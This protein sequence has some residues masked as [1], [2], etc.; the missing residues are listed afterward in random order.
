[1]CFIEITIVCPSRSLR[2]QNINRYSEPVLW[3]V[4]FQNVCYEIAGISSYARHLDYERFRKVADGCGA[5]LM[6]DIAHVSGLIA[7]EVWY[8][9][10]NLFI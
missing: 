9:F 7:A 3:P 5:F 8:I 4:H 1:M 10:L 6:A 2:V